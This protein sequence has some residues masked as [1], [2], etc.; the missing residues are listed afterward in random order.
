MRNILISFIFFIPFVLASAPVMQSSDIWPGTANNDTGLLGFCS[1][2][3]DESSFGTGFYYNWYKD[4]SLQSSSN[5]VGTS[6]GQF[7]YKGYSWQNPVYG[8]NY[9]FGGLTVDDEFIYYSGYDN[10]VTGS[11]IWKETLSD[12]IAVAN[13][14]LPAYINRSWD[15]EYYND[16]F[17]IL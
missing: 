6:L 15:I 17:Y 10:T 4:G 5:T 7:K 14:S 13:F 12:G 8:S 11:Y 1:A 16:S 3:D 2:T 9:A